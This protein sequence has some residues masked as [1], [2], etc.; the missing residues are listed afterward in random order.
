MQ[1]E[2]ITDGRKCLIILELVGIQTQL[3]EIV[4]GR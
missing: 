4:K 2:M 3:A 1:K